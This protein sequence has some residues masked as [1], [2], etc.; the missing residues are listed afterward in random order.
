[1]LYFAFVHLNEKLNFKC[2]TKKGISAL[3]YGC[4]RNILG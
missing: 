2:C 4:Y 3:D 1:M